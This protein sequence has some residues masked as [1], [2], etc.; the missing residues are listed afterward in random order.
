[1]KLD[2]CAKIILRDVFEL[3]LDLNELWIG[4]TPRALIE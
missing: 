2:I 3:G 4:K 1:M